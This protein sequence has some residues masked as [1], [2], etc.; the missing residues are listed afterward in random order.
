MSPNI[1]FTSALED[2][3]L[4]RR[5]A[6]LQSILGWMKGEQENLLSYDDVRKQLRAIESSDRKLQEIPVNSI[7][8]SV[9]RCADFTRNFLLKHSISGERW[10]RVKAAAQDMVGLPPIEVYQIGEVYFVQDGNHRV[11]IARQDGAKSIQAYVKVVHTKISIAPNIQPDDLIIKA[12]YLDITET[13][14]IDDLRPNTDLATTSPGSYPTI[15]QQIEAVKFAMEL[16]RGEEVQFEDAV[17]YWHDWIYLPIVQIIR[18]RDMLEKFPYRTETDLYIW[19]IKFQSELTRELGWDITAEN[20]AT[21]LR[22][23]ISPRFVRWWNKFQDAILSD[24]LKPLVPV[25]L[26]RQQ[27][28]ASHQGR[29][30]ADIMVVLTGRD[31]DW[32][33]LDYALN[34]AKQEGSRI[35]GLYV[36]P[37]RET[38]KTKNAHSIRE[39][40]D[41]QC[42]KSRVSG[43]LVF[44]ASRK[45]NRLILSRARWVDL[46]V[47][48]LDCQDNPRWDKLLKLLVYRCPTP[49][50]AIQKNSKSSI[51]KVLLAF[52]GSPKSEEALFLATYLAKFWEVSL[53]VLTVFGGKKIPNQTL[54]KAGD[55][56]AM[57]NVEAE[58][59]K[60]SGPPSTAV[61]IFAT[62][63][64]CDLIISGGYGYKLIRKMLFGSIIDKI[65]KDSKH[66]VLICK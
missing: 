60:A 27:Q 66:S 2:F 34:I 57:Y 62:E 59:I 56:L 16:K 36:T 5:Q 37:V 47:L 4:A 39:I 54:A 20:A 15:L 32:H 38:L 31:T 43:D 46:V 1:H 24:N 65:L 53:V 52:D 30:F 17:L 41:K 64:S 21:M 61:N 13:T 6:A 14:H 48:P 7:V 22:A 58:Y 42:E 45:S 8:G 10:A 49:I 50:F 40:F 3:R 33:V 25:G 11:S 29:L 44:E 23:K 9:N 63:N 35:F 19:L 28:L 12:E 51:R 55:Y 26:W 18:D